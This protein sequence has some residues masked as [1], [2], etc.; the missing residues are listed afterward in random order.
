MSDVR[1]RLIRCLRDPRDIGPWSNDLLACARA[2]NVHLLLA[3]PAFG[4]RDGFGRG[5][6]LLPEI[7]GALRAEAQ[8][9]ER[10]SERRAR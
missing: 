9:V 5:G 4:S 2:N 6:K 7:E 1:T 8:L 3:E 10:M